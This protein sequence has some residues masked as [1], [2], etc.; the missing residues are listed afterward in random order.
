MSHL[1]PLFLKKLI[2]FR[3]QL[4]Q[5]P[6]VSLNEKNTAKTIIEFVKSYK[7]DEVIE[8]IG[9]NG[10][11]IIFKGKT[12]GQNTAIRAEIDALPIQEKG[13]KNYCSKIKG[14]AH[15]CGHDGHTVNVLSLLDFLSKNKPHKGNVILLFQPAEEI[16]AGAAEMLQD[17]QLK[18]L[19]IHSIF[20]LHNVPK[21]EMG[22]VLFREQHFCAASKGIKLFFEGKTAHAA[23]PQNGISPAKAIAELIIQLSDLQDKIKLKSFGIGTIVHAKIGEEAFGISPSKGALMLTIRSYINEDLALMT[24]HILNAAQQKA[25]EYNLVF[26]TVETEVFPA[27]VNHQDGIN[28]LKKSIERNQLQS[29]ELKEPFK[30]SEDF[31]HFLNNYNGAFF[32]LGSGVN[33]PNLHHEDYD[34]PDELIPIAHQLFQSIIQ[35]IHY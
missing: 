7:P 27:T 1:D 5:Y 3:H 31:G 6:E 24:Q 18:K 22:K 13:N 34:Y 28:L 30:W 10:F 9:G 16:G 4:H 20:G 2:D 8:N 12:T 23:E 29:E 32:G 11:V 17:D 35:Q 15:L 14:V 26:T 25:K 19:D 33:Q 21:Y